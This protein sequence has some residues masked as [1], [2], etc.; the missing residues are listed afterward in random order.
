MPWDNWPAIPSTWKRVPKLCWQYVRSFRCSLAGLPLQWDSRGNRCHAMS[1]HVEE[2]LPARCS[3]R[4]ADTDLL[5][6]AGDAEA[7]GPGDTDDGDEER[8]TGKGS[9][10]DRCNARSTQLRVA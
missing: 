9:K 4:D 2:N 6:A 7:Q 1:E 8:H 3:Q 10:E 5:S